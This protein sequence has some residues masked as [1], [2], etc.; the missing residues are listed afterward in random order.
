MKWLLGAVAAGVIATGVQTIRLDHA[1]AD[2]VTARSDADLAYDAVQTLKVSLDTQ[3]AAVDAFKADSDSR[4]QVIA[5]AIRTG[6]KSA[7]GHATAA[8]AL[9][10]YT[11]K[12]ADACAQ[13]VDLD[14][15]INP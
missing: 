8:Q 4:A 6:L 15:E 3:N 13:L 2:L 5:D 9:A 7:A 1:R 11:P 10:V 14:R 12:G